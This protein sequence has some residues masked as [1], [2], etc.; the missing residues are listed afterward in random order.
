MTT[1]KNQPHSEGCSVKVREWIFVF[2]S[3]FFLDK[4]PQITDHPKSSKDVFPGKPV[5]FTVQATGT[6]PLSYQWQR[7]SE[8]EEGGRED[9]HPCPIKWCNGATLTIPKVKMSSEG[10]YCRVVSNYAGKQT[11]NPARLEVS[12]SAGSSREN[13]KTIAIHRKQKIWS[14]VHLCMCTYLNLNFTLTS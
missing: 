12:W 11:S 8:E 7:K 10:S 6:E 1:N 5:S 4:P 13:G 3:F 9:W 14:I 2:I